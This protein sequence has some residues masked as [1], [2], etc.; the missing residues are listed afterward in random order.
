M[1]YRKCIR[2]SKSRGK[3]NGECG[4]NLI[5][6]G[7][8]ASPLRPWAD[9]SARS[10]PLGGLSSLASPGA[11]T[12]LALV[13]NAGSQPILDPLDQ[14]R[15]FSKFLRWFAGTLKLEKFCLKDGLA[16]RQH[17]WRQPHDRHRKQV[18]EG[19]AVG[20]VKAVPG[21]LLSGWAAAW[22]VECKTVSDG[23]TGR[24]VQDRAGSKS[25]IWF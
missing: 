22:T 24:A 2:E 15:R 4:A 1:P 20:M 23:E 25:C 16:F 14:N 12:T 6:V 18:T 13:R 9:A 5:S 21:N 7:R 17:T 10:W 3:Q 8:D 11:A 19:V